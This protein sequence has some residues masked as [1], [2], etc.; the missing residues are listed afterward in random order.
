MLSERNRFMG[1]QTGMYTSNVRKTSFKNCRSLSKP[2]TPL[3]WWVYFIVLLHKALD[4]I[5][6]SEYS[7]MI[8]DNH[9]Y[10]YVIGYIVYVKL[11]EGK[12]KIMIVLGVIGKCAFVT[13]F[14]VIE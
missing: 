6:S 8:N 5:S 4:K 13:A 14:K 7:I 12:D 10:I 9:R 1:K 3:S 2:K 11:R